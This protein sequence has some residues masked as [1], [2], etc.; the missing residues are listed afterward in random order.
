MAGRISEA[1]M[2]RKREV[3]VAS[4][5]KT[6]VLLQQ[7]ADPDTGLETGTFVTAGDPGPCDVWVPGLRDNPFAGMQ[8]GGGKTADRL[9]EV[10]IDLWVDPAPAIGDQIAVGTQLYA[11]QDLAVDESYPLAL[12]IN[13]EWIPPAPE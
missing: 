12:L 10:P 11:V 3:Y 4:M 13:G 1:N 7:G 6:C 9:L 5:E 2:A 8:Q